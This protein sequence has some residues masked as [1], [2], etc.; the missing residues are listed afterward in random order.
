MH[1]RSESNETL[2]STRGDLFENISPIG[3]GRV[4]REFFPTDEARRP[5]MTT[6]LNLSLHDA[7]TEP[8]PVE[9][10]GRITRWAWVVYVVMALATPLV[11]YSGPDVMSPSATV[12]A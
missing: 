8:H 9:R 3:A 2:T 10:P 5:I 1:R 11:M 7:R 12:I 4:P 6:N